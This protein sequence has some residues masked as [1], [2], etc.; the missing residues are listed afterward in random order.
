MYVRVSRLMNAT[1]V[2]S[3]TLIIF[4]TMCIQWEGGH[5]DSKQVRATDAEK[6]GK[7]KPAYSRYIVSNEETY[8]PRRIRCLPVQVYAAQKAR[9]NYLMDPLMFYP[10]ER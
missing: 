5:C 10:K 1:R 3:L 4:H 9:D 7:Y 8:I 6:T 2:F